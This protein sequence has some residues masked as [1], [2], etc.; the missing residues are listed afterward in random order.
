MDVLNE[1]WFRL[2]KYV[3]PFTFLVKW[4]ISDLQE[5]SNF[6]VIQIAEAVPASL[7]FR[8]NRHY[9]IKALNGGDAYLKRA[10]GARL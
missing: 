5:N 3:P 2:E 8:A 10:L 7:I 6:S 4:T 9:E 1:V